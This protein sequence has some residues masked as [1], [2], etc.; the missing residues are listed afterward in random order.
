LLYLE[1]K[2]SQ[3]FGTTVSDIQFWKF[4]EF[5]SPWWSSNVW[6]G[7][8]VGRPVGRKEFC[9]PICTNIHLFLWT[10]CNYTFH[11]IALVPAFVESETGVDPGFVQIK[12]FFFFRYQCFRL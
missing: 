4:L 3:Q 10:S 8:Y 6:P 12:F 9:D 7:L 11:I 5:I 2:S 1:A